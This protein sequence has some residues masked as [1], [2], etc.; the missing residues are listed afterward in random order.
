MRGWTVTTVGRGRGNGA[1]VAA[2]NLEFGPVL[3]T[4]K[5]RFFLFFSE[6]LKFLSFFAKQGA[7]KDRLGRTD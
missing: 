6:I 3:Q 4:Y 1:E 5:I 7:R 2:P